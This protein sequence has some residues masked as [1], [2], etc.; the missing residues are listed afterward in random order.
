MQHA[1]AMHVVELE[2]LYLRAV[3]ERCVRRREAQR[4]PPHA[5]RGILVDPSERVAQDPAPL[6][7]RAIERAAQGI[8]NEQLDPLAHLGGNRAVSK[9]GYKAGDVAG[10]HPSLHANAPVAGKLSPPPPPRPAV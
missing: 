10:I 8:E 5:A 1:G 7:V 9:P 2:A 3:R 6:Q 4:S